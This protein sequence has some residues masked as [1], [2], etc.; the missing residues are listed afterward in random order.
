MRA[1]PTAAVG[2]PFS[3]AFIFVASEQGAG[4]GRQHR[5]AINVLGAVTRSDQ[6]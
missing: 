1:D 3:Q 6:W 2:G 4:Q 5:L